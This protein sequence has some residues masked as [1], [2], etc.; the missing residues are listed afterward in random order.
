[1]EAA[2]QTFHLTQ[3]QYTDT[4]P[5]SPCAATLRYKLEIKLPISPSQ[6]ILSPG[7]PVPLL[8]QQR[9][10]PDKAATGEPICLVTGG[11]RR[12]I[13]SESG[14]RT[15][16]RCSRGGRLTTRPTTR[17]S[18]ETTTGVQAAGRPQPLSALYNTGYLSQSGSGDVIFQPNIGTP[19]VGK[20]PYSSG[21]LI[22]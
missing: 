17:E 6:N 12:K 20:E 19:L 18:S 4:R 9:P 21:I 11:T 3:S 14:D 8:T 1:M 15:Q 5:T 7:Q 10:T 2:D 22:K 16:D 13:Y